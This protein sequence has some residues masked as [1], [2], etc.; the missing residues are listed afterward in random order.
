MIITCKPHGI[1]LIGATE[2]RNATSSTLYLIEEGG[3]WNEIT[4]TLVYTCMYVHV[5][6]NS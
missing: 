4:S 3:L 5:A 6:Y 2:F 1:N